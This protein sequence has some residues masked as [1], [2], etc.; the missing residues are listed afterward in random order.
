MRPVIGM[1]IGGMHPVLT[2]VFTDKE[3][4]KIDIFDSV[5]VRKI[6]QFLMGIPQW[7]VFELMKERKDSLK[8]FFIKSMSY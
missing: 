5:F 3:I 6:R 2:L 1:K 7:I 8:S 4:E